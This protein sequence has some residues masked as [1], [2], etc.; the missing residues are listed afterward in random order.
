MKTSRLNATLFG[1]ISGGVVALTVFLITLGR[2]GLETVVQIDGDPV[3]RITTGSL[4]LLVLI[5]SALVGLLIGAIGYG[6][7]VSAEPDAP[8]FGIGYLLPVSAS[9]A[10]VVSYAVLRIGIGAFGDIE[11]GVVTV[12]AFR[13]GLIVLVMGLAAGAIT[14]GIAD[15]LARPELFS[16]GGEA[17]PSS[18]REVM[19]AMLDAVS[20]PLAAAVVA[21][22]GAIPLSLV[23]IE[24]EG[25]AATVLFAVVG[26]LV[27]GGTTL[28]AA[29]PWDRGAP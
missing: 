21:A 27:L 1:A 22:L 18:P 9:T 29:R 17:W 28:V 26:A 2:F 15:T 19:R 10:A 8:R 12:G 14:S 16:F 11:G 7:G 23:L 6:V 25:D 20:A 5:I 3:F 13:T 24:L 4:Y